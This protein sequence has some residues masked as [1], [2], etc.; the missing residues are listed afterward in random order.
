[1]QTLEELKSE[2]SFLL[3]KLKENRKKQSAIH[4]KRKE[5]FLKALINL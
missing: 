1:L 4:Q 3:Q 5:D 2:E